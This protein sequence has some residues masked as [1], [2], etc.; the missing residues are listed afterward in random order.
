[1][2]KT[3]KNFWK[4][5]WQT[6]PF[7]M[8]MGGFNVAIALFCLVAMGFDDRVLLG[9]SVWLK[10]LKF[11]I[12][13]AIFCGTI[14]WLISIYPYTEKWKKWSGNF[15]AI[16]IFIEILTIFIPAAMG[17]KS[18]YNMSTPMSAI[19][20]GIMGFA[21][22]STVLGLFIMAIQSFYKPLNTSKSIIWSI[23]F[24]WITMFLAFWGGELMIGQSAHNIGIPDGGEGLPMTNWSTEGGDLRVMHFFGIHALQILPLLVYFLGQLSIF[25]TPKKLTFASIL[26]GLGYLGLTSFLFYQALQG[27]PF[28]NFD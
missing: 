7:S 19:T 22:H 4:T 1:M 3:I 14:T 24:A 11:A 21:I 9:V 8:K 25:E 16:L 26:I 28:F 6:H 2:Q 18:H 23:R 13:L 17:I 12:S 10:P 27:Q 20:F 5:L 15:F